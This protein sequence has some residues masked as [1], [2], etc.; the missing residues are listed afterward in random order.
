MNLLQYLDSL[1]ILSIIFLVFFEV[2]LCG[3]LC[4]RRLK[5]GTLA[6]EEMGSELGLSCRG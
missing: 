1:L 2:V 5:E 4:C 3:H 6:E